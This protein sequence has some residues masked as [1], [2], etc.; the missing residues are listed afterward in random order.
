MKAARFN[1]DD[2][3]VSIEEVDVPPVGPDEV[4]VDIQAASLCGSDVHFFHGTLPEPTLNPVT[5]GHEGAGIVDAVGE[6]VSNVSVGEQV[7]IHYV[8]SCGTCKPCL[9]GYDQRCR[10][11][12]HFGD[13]RH[14]TFA[15][16]VTI[17]AENAIP[18]ADHV[19]IEWAS[20]SAC[21]VATPYHAL[22]RSQIENGDTAVVFGIGGIGMHAVMWADF[23]GAGEV[24]AV[25]IDDRNLQGAEDYGADVLVN[26]SEEDPTDVVETRTDGWGADVVLECSGSEAAMNQALEAIEGRTRFATGNVVLVGIQDEPIPSIDFMGLREG[27]LAVSGDHTRNELRQIVDLLNGGKLDLDA[28]VTHRMPLDDLERAVDTLEHGDERVGRIVLDTT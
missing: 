8:H 13:H 28:S 24:I 4:R 16:Y 9:Q 2:S 23:F 14:G 27:Y 12:G 25:D 5:M 18:V 10:E 1:A 21:A 15:E 7:A 6:N 20:I 19:P 11:R 26:A 22:Q 17:P 3:T